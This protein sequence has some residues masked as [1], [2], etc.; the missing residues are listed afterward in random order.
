MS[1][2]PSHF[3][4]MTHL[5]TSTFA[6]AALACSE[7][8]HIWKTA[9]LIAAGKA[10]PR[11]HISHVPDAAWVLSSDS[12][13]K[14]EECGFVG[15]WK[16]GTRL[17]DLHCSGSILIEKKN[18]LSFRQTVKLASQTRSEPLPKPSHLTH[19]WNHRIHQLKHRGLDFG[20]QKYRQAFLVF[21][22][23]CEL[24]LIPYT[25]YTQT[26]FLRWLWYAV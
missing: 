3:D 12:G 4:F 9:V 25:P 17:L 15:T 11:C 6:A 16:E 8:V 26:A 22:L 2:L 13:R 10:Y 20:E 19:I 21:C 18:C 1:E 7:W 5:Q 24:F 14:K 23:V